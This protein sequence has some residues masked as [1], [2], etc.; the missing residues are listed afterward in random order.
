MRAFHNKKNLLAEWCIYNARPEKQ[1]R[2]VLVVLPFV[3][4]MGSG[5]KCAAITTNYLIPYLASI[6]TT[7]G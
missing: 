5:S 1:R 2:A 4:T 7:D 3:G 6:S